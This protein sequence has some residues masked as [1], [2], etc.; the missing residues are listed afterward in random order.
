MTAAVAAV[1]SEDAEEGT[2]DPNHHSDEDAPSSPG[3][4]TVQDARK[5]KR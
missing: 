5:L 3:H 1:Q 2:E 4:D